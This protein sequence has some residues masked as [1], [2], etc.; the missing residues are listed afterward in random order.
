MK[1]WRSC[2]SLDRLTFC[3]V[4][5]KCARTDPHFL[6]PCCYTCPVIHT[7]S[8]ANSG[9]TACTLISVVQLYIRHQCGFYKAV[10]LASKCL[11]V[12]D[13]F[14]PHPLK[15]PREGREERRIEGGRKIAWT[16]KIYDR[17]PPLLQW[18]L[19][20]LHRYL[21]QKNNTPIRIDV[22]PEIRIVLEE[23]KEISFCKKNYR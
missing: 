12:G 23:E 16:P 14:S 20:Q 5:S 6:V 4:A 10:W 22:L 15:S 13:R 8:S 18:H 17:S 1:W 2:G 19:C 11:A 7:I 3:S 9:W 21:M